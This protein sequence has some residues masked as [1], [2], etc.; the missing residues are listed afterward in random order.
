MPWGEHKGIPMADVD[1]GYLLWLFRQ[2]WIRDWPDIHEYL[3]E[4]QDALL[5]EDAESEADQ[6]RGEFTSYE[7]YMRH[8]H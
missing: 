1:Q 6:P 5:L 7:D 3:V 2:K 4:N 8:G